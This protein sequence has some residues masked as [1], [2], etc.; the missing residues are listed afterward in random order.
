[1][2]APGNYIQ[3]KSRIRRYIDTKPN[4][5]LIHYNIA[6]KLY[7]YQ[8]TIIPVT[9]S[10]DDAPPHR[11]SRVDETYTTVSEEIRKKIDVG[12]E[13]V[14]IILTRINNDIYSIVDAY[15]NAKEMWKA[16]ER[17]K[18]GKEIDKAPSTPKSDHEVICKP[19]NNKLI[20][21]SNTRNKNVDNTPRLD[22]RMRY[23]RQTGQYENQRAVNVVR[24][25]ETEVTPAIDEDTRPIFDK[26]PLEKVHPNDDYNVF[27]TKRQHLE[28]L[29]SI[30]DTYVL[31]KV[32]SNITPDSSNMCNDEGKVNHDTTQDKERALLAS[33]IQNMKLEI[34][35]SKKSN[36]SLR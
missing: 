16:I 35:E 4:C 13:V 31:E 5:E 2:L 23:D 22:R 14:H 15:P 25:R 36:K 8:W 27:S 12:A 29:E 10:N 7:E 30:N 32:D 3:W 9:P 17:L 33:L 26:E 24:N 1:M 11:K 18:Q 6:N 28:H 20:A 21:F 34:D 19:T